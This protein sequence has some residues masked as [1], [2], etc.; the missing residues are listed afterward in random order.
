MSGGELRKKLTLMNISAVGYKF[1]EYCEIIN[2]EI[3]IFIKQVHKLKEEAISNL[4]KVMFAT[5]IQN[6]ID[7]NA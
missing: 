4:Q 5:I 2:Q 7:I 6:T 1:E 3:D